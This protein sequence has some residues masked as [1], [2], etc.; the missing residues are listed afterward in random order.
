MKLHS[1]RGAFGILTVSLAAMLGFAPSVFA[2]YGGSG[3]QQQQTPPPSLQQQT[4]P[5]PAAP[6]AAPPPADPEEEKAY[7]A[8]TDTAAKSDAYD[9]QIQIG[10]QYLQKYPTGHYAEQVYA[11]LVNAY[12]QKQQLDKMYAAGDKALSMNPDDVSVLVLV[13]WVIPHYYNPNDIE[14]DR[15]LAKA[16]A[17]EKRALD[18]LA[19]LPKPDGITDEQFAKSKKGALEQAHSG[20]GLVYFR[21]QNIENSV[22]EMQS[23]TQIDPTADPVDS[24]ILGVGLTQ[25]KRYSEAA[26]AFQKCSQMPGPVQD[27]CTKG[28][29]EAKKQAASQPAAPAA[30]PAAPATPAP[31]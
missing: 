29:A 6:Q 31:K 27:R 5:K 10:E 4:P 24:Y 16:E 15:R 14:A 30:A 28:A 23:A 8:F 3:G 12:L 25:L 9:Q 22:T 11:R 1:I 7:K 13:G 17:Y 20:L 19:N 18:L 26:D 21:Q 2:Q